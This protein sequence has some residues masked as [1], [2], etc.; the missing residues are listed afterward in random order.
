MF[1]GRVGWLGL[2]VAGVGCAGVQP[3]ATPGLTLE[4]AL[5]DPEARVMWVGAHPDDES[6]V[7]SALARA[8]VGLQRPCALVVMNRG[9]GGECLRK[10]GCAPTLGEVRAREMVLVA[11]AYDAEL[12]HFDY[13]NAPLPVSSFP[14]R[15]ELGRRWVEEGD[16]AARIEQVILRFKPTVLLTFDPNN[17]F[18]G[19]P[20]HQLASRFAL[21]AVRRAAGHGHAVANVYLGLNRFWMYRALGAGDPAV[22]TEAFDTH[23]RCGPVNT[24]CLD[25]ALAATRAHRSQAGDMGRVRSLRPQLGQVYL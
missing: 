24:P 17:G 25:V 13:F 18:T 6:L 23:A 21:D 5:Q 3:A 7:G 11:R 9:G 4:E 12:H 1:E 15:P 2:L 22:P 16:P 14:S 10:G 8:C 19:H 20:E